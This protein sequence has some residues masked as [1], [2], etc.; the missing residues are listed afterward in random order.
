[1]KKFLCFLI[2]LIA[3]I[4][5]FSSVVFSSDIPDDVQKRLEK[6]IVE[7]VGDREETEVTADSYSSSDDVLSFTLSYSGKSVNVTTPSEYLESEIKAVFFYDETLFCEGERL[8]YI[9]RSSFSSVTLDGAR[10]G[11]NYALRG[12]SGKTEALF[13]VDRVYED[14][15]TLKPYFLSSPLP[16]MKLERINDFSLSLRALSSFRF[17][18]FGGSLSLYYS[19]FCYPVTPF[20]SIAVIMDGK[21]AYHIDAG[22]SASFSLSSVWPAV[23]VVKNLSIEGEFALGAAYN[24]SFGL[25]SE[26]GLALRWT[27]SR[28]FSA[29]VG[30]TGYSGNDYISLT[31]GGKL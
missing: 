14:A 1:M 11:Q 12:N 6:A 21:T 7:A 15:V 29:A 19:T 20:V 8:D 24:G 27:F 2:L 16:G 28:V 25:S 26:Y 23:P 3:L 31:V 9:Y 13:I 18:G 30:I 17:T 10:R 4:P 5:L 22:L